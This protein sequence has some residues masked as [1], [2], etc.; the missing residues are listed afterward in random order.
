LALFLSATSI[1]LLLPALQLDFY[2]ILLL[3][4]PLNTSYI[5]Q[6]P[7][8]TMYLFVSARHKPRRFPTYNLSFSALARHQKALRAPKNASRFSQLALCVSKINLDPENWTLDYTI[9]DLADP[10]LANSAVF[11]ALKARSKGRIVG[12]VCIYLDFAH[13]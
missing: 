8:I 13:H 3:S 12:S 9:F 7:R 11:R 5:K 6:M 2:R 10:L 4:F 1:S